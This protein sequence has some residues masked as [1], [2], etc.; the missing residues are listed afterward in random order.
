[1]STTKS[2]VLTTKSPVV[3]RTIFRLLLAWGVTVN[4]PVEVNA[5][6]ERLS[7]PAI[8]L[9]PAPLISNTPADVSS[10]VVI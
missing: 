9:V 2:S 4:A 3:E 8:S 10:R 6:P 1:V 7:V 5:P